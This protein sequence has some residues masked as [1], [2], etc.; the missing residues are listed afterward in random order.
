MVIVSCIFQES[1]LFFAIIMSAAKVL[2]FL[3]STFVLHHTRANSRIVKT[4]SNSVLLETCCETTQTINWKFKENFLFFKW[5]PLENV[6]KDTVSLD[7]NSSLCI[8][9]VSLLH[10]GVYQ[11]MC[12]DISVKNYSLEV[13]GLL[14]I[15]ILFQIFLSNL[16]YGFCL[17][18]RVNRQYLYCECYRKQVV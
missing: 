1:K 10:E 12:N 16:Q 8:S 13:E 11:C 17:L 14:V 7:V 6:I 18:Y 2:I 15:S 5:I 4:F 3:L 9:N